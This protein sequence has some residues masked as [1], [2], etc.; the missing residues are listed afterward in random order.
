MLQTTKSTLNG[1]TSRR[2]V[3]SRTTWTR[4]ILLLIGIIFHVTYVFS[5]FDI[6]FT[7]PLVHGMKQHQ[8]DMS[9][10]ARRLI[11]FVADGL[12]ADRLF[13]PLSSSPPTVEDGD[14]PPLIA[15][16]GTQTRAPFLHDIQTR[17]GSWGVSHTRVPTESRPGHVAIIAGFYE[18]VSAVTKGNLLLISYMYI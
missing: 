1:T 12:R 6:Y 17:V 4:N 10:P 2:G 5:I 15:A 7:S 9:A 14:M 18:D 16:D 13:E 3:V 8:L 11:L